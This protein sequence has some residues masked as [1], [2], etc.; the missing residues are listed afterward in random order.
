M[1]TA[2][3][4]WQE[5][6]GGLPRTF[7]WIWTGTLVNRLGSFV[8]PFLALYLTAAQGYSI[9]FAGLV[10]TLYGL[11]SA[12]STIVAGILADRIGRKPT[13]LGA[14][15]SSTAAMLALGV[16]HGPVSIAATAA[17]LGFTSNAARPASG[18]LIADVVA[19]ADRVRAYGL[20]YWAIN[21]GFAFASVVAGVV[22]TYSYFVLFLIDAATTLAMAVL[23]AAFVREPDRPAPVAAT[24]GGTSPGMGFV[25]RDRPFIVF[26]G[27]SF[28]V[29]LLYMQATVTLPLSMT[30][31]GLSPAVYGSVAAVNGILIVLAQLP[32][33]RLVREW[34]P[35]TVLALA[36]GVTG[37]GFGLTA[38]A[39]S[40]AM[41]A[42]TVVVWT[43]GEILHA[44][45]SNAVVA[46]MA[47]AALRGRY[48]GMY[49][50]S[51]QGAAFL[52][53][54]AGGVV[55]EQLGDTALWLACGVVG[56]LAAGG[57]LALRP[58]DPRRESAHVKP[59]IPRQATTAATAR[60]E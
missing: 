4:L 16:S 59:V 35:T 55:Y 21:L 9:A 3:R 5:T 19:P 27:L 28:L 37:S 52:A 18:A 7:W 10:A 25:L 58:A 38:V 57:Q 31:A 29:A 47:P 50:L 1:R 43:I 39:G 6:M 46:N 13:L 24:G 30:D 33:G 48:Q 15:L 49:A 45:T 34:Q 2:R 22:A 51:W 26:V 60:T 53:P 40:A 42:A 56:A 32:I 11:G 54:I 36:A 8:V 23:I 17:L 41:F 14:L 12:A 44:P 20:N